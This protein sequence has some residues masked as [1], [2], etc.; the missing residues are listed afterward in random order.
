MRWRF[1]VFLPGCRPNRVRAPA[2]AFLAAALV[3]SLVL[4]LAFSLSAC[5]VA[6]DEPELDAMT[7]SE[8]PYHH[9]PGGGF[10]NPAG[11]PERTA[12][13]LDMFAF[14]FRQFTTKRQ[15]EIPPG[16]H[17]EDTAVAGQLAAA[18]NPSVT[19]LGHAAFIVR[20]GGKVILTDPFLGPRAGPA[21]FG[22]KRFIAPALTASELPR[23]DVMLVSHN[24]YDHLDVNTLEAY[25]HKESTQIIVPLGLGSFFTRLGYLKVAEFEWWE[26]WE[27]DGL[28]IVTL[29]AVHFSRRGLF[30]FNRTLW[31]SFA[32]LTEHD[33]IWFSGD[34]A[35]GEVFSEI[36]DRFGPFDLALVGIGAYEPRKIMEPAH[37]TPEE[38]V[39]I[40]RAVGARKALGMHWGTIMLTP[41]DPFEAPQRFRQAADSQGFGAEN[42][43]IL[44]VGETRSLNG[45]E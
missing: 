11:S 34:T 14:L 24:H 1:P 36:G 5:T 19:W 30:D 18:G 9:A 15:P 7:E 41:E 20:T 13:F 39:E 21:G 22:P 38:A 31:A 8:K 43:W 23:A 3:H 40:S 44:K 42:I 33:R 45:N 4:S 10:R 25:P 29:P 37:A 27:S 26:T 35:R 16:H 2:G 28:Q 6:R 12:D 17:L 32:I